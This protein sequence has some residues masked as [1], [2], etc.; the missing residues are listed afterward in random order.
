MENK[1]DISFHGPQQFPPFKLLN[2]LPT[3]SQ[4]NR[5]AAPIKCELLV[6]SFLEAPDY[7]ALSYTWGSSTQDWPVQIHVRPSQHHP[8]SGSETKIVHVTKHLHAALLR[9]QQPTVPRLV[10]I[11]QLCIDQNN[12]PEKNAS[13]S[14]MAEIYRRAKA[15]IVWLGDVAMLDEDKEVI[16]DATERMN[17]R[18]IE[19][20]WSDAKDQ[21]ILKDLIGFR[22]HGRAYE[23][24]QKRRQ[25]LT[26]FLNQ[27]WFTRAW[28]FQEAVVG[29]RGII[30]CG[31][32][33]MDMDVF[34]NLLDGV[35]DLDLQEV[36]EASSIMRS[37]KGYKPMFAIREAR[38]ESRNGLAFKTKSQWLA[39]LWQAMG[40]LSATDQRDKVY[41]FLAFSDS[42]EDARISP[43]YELPVRSV[44]TDAAIR[45]IRSVHSLNVLELALKRDQSSADLPSWV[46]DFSKP[47]PSLPFMTH[48]EG[49]G[50]FQASRRIRY[51]R[52]I[53]SANTSELEVLGHIIS[54]VN[55][56]CPTNYHT[57]DPSQ[58]LH[59][60]TK[61]EEAITWVLSQLNGHT[62]TAPPDLPMKVLRTLLAEGAAAD[63]TPN[64][65]DYD[66]HDILAVSQNEPTILQ[67]F[68]SGLVPSPSQSSDP[69]ATRDLKIQ[70][71]Y[72]KWMK[73]ISEILHNKKFFLTKDC[74]LGLAY[75]AIKEGD[76]ICI[77]LGA[78]TP[79]VLRTCMTPGGKRAEQQYQFIAQC[80]LDEW[81]HGEE[82]E[83]RTWTEEGAETFVLV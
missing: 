6:G 46:P 4:G 73:A 63:D 51:P 21:D 28:V 24:G 71:R 10:W 79:T 55:S 49:G 38:F 48:N 64:N 43:S 42:Q 13:V 65:M 9:L 52:A 78:K 40:N 2:I 33:E 17:F 35:C 8:P 22:A 82:H 12:I 75:D 16:I 72:Y 18:P 66:P 27:A 3:S 74:D 76:L 32:L 44:Y 81:M 53:S 34:I 14:L 68:H 56:I 29:K 69:P 36:G 80:Y 5:T 37:S 57:Y 39:T 58:T 47:L 20:E 15:V 50:N 59:D 54:T 60:I 62:H 41:A 23:L 30:L 83:G 45:S 31:S 7:E 77:L 19:R 61:L 11:D 26:K 25:L 67:A 1:T 70:Y